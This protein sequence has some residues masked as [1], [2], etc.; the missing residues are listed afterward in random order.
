MYTIY[1]LF[2]TKYINHNW[3]Y[4]LSYRPVSP[5]VR[6]AIFEGFYELNLTIIL[7][8]GL[9][10]L[11]RK[12][13][14]LSTTSTVELTPWSRV[15]LEKLRVRSASQEIPRILWSPK[16]HYCVQKALQPVAIL[17]ET[18]LIHTFQPYFSKIHFNIILQSTP[19]SS[20]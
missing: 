12:K 10:C 17:S 2:Q 13:L 6:R 9:H 15:L 5:F 11:D 7:K 1:K 18:N 8:Y 3:V 4:I 20:E 19:K 14:N 16:V